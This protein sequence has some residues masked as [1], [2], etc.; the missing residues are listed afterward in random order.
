MDPVIRPGNSLLL[1]AIQSAE[2]IPAVPSAA[3]DVIPFESESLSYTGPYKSEQTD[4]ANGTFAAGAPLVIGQAATITWRSR[5]KGA[6]AG[7]VYTSSVKPPLHAALSICGWMGQ[8][9]AA[10]A[11]AVLTA[12]T[13]TTATLGTGFAA[14]AQLYRG[15][16]LI[17]TGGTAGG[18][19]SQIVDY[20]AAK[21]ATLA[22]LFGTALSATNSAAIPANWTYCPTS[23]V[24]TASRLTMHPLGTLYLYEDGILHAW[25]DCRGTFDPDGDAAKPG[26]GT[27]SVTGIYAGPA[28]AAMPSNP[29]YPGQSAPLLV[30]GVGG[31][32]PVFQINR[33]GLPIEKWSLKSN[34]QIETPADPNST[35]GFAAG[36]LSDRAYMLQCD[37][38]Q[39]YVATRNV[40]AEIAAFTQMTGALQFGSTSGNRVSIT[41]PLIQ[42]VEAT[43]GT[44][45]KLRTQSTMYQCM[46]PGRDSAGRDGDVAICFS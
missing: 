13:T 26:F 39:T 31:L 20:T 2:G 3:T 46:T 15:M 37:P 22:D 9:T 43:P 11:A 28:D 30:Q 12:G 19:L 24:D 29:V 14:T 42:P 34:S 4:E 44:A 16:P 45:G 5:L 36:Q 17:L 10:V 38:K 41:L 23:P 7:V 1:L 6:G 18:R 8:F 21:V 27:F 33:K 35:Y 40:L 25:T 32:G